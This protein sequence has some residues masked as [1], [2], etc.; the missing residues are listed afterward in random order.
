MPIFIYIFPVP[1]VALISYF[2][3]SRRSSPLIKRTALAAL[4]LIGL[5]ILTSLFVIFRELS[6]KAV[7]VFED[8]PAEPASPQSG[9][10]SAA[11]IFGI[12]ILLFLAMIVFLTLRESRR[13]PKQEEKPKFPGG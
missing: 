12:F 10:I 6:G 1:L 7:A 3:L 11:V 8:I 2:A 13:F 5:S 9:N 4:I